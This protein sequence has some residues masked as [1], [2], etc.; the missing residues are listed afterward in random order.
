[1]MKE[2]DEMRRHPLESNDENAQRMMNDE[3][4]PVEVS[5]HDMMLR[6][7][8]LNLIMLPTQALFLSKL[9]FNSP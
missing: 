5:A 9:G 4:S 3:M 1:M 8:S 6:F 7:H 2:D